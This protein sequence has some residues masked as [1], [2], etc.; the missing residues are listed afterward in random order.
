MGNSNERQRRA[1]AM[2]G[3]NKKCQLWVGNVDGQWRQGLGK[4]NGKGQ[5]ARLFFEGD[6]NNSDGQEVGAALIIKD[7]KLKSE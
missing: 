1:A 5:L 7:G 3:S 2:D 6:G 4:D